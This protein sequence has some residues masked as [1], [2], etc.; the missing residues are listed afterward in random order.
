MRLALL[1][2]LLA[3]STLPSRAGAAAQERLAATADPR[4][5]QEALVALVARSLE[6]RG[7]FI[8]AERAWLNVSR[9]LPAMGELE[10]RPLWASADG[11]AP[12]LPLAFEL[13]PPGSAGP[14]AAINA[15]LA[16]TLLRE[17]PVATHR[18]RKGS[19]VTC[20]DF[21]VERRA[22]REI[23]SA[24]RTTACDLTE[25]SVALRELASGDVVNRPDIGPP[26]AVVA[27]S[28]VHVS[29]ESGAVSVTVLATALADGRIGDELDVRLRHPIRTLKA[30]VVA[31]GAAQL[32]TGEL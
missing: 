9:P 10:V 16:V 30:R 13:R 6:P 2:L 31:P 28:P 25:Q 14:A 5:L 20:A 21:Q 11:R 29:V 24:A 8:D 3:L 17:V 26:L 23:S 19:A 22:L 4:A 18:I 15:T 7:F 12:P 27:G 1:T 32:V